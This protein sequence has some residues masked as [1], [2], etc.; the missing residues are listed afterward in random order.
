MFTSAD[1]PVSLESIPIMIKKAKINPERIIKISRW[2][3]RN[4]FI[5]YG[6]LKK[7]FNFFAQKFLRLLFNSKLTDFT[8]PILIAPTY[9][10]KN[11]IFIYSATTF[12]QR[13]FHHITIPTNRFIF[14]VQIKIWN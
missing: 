14:F 1:I 4:S 9:I 5:K 12:T 8:S 10:Y 6:Y 13:I 2:L 7:F 11:I 3:E